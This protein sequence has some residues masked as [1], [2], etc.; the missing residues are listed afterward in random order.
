MIE[1]KGNYTNLIKH[2]VALIEHE[3]RDASEAK[4][5][6]T[7]KSVQT[8]WSRD[9]DVG[10]CRLVAE[11]LLVLLDISATVEDLSLDFWHVLAETLILVLDLECKLTCVAHDQDADFAVDWLDLLQSGQH[12][13]GC[14]SET[15]LGLAEDIGSEDCLR[16]AHLLDCRVMLE[17]FVQSCVRAKAL[18]SRAERP[19]IVTVNRNNMPARTPPV[20]KPQKP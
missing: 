5:L 3:S 20:V 2:L 18:V 1:W 12:K 9:D 13:D 7:H 6:F 10:V 8:T 19:S 11:E 17:G 16:N 15:G 14:L 4:L